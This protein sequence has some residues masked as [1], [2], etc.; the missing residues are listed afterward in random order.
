MFFASSLCGTVTI[1]EAV[2]VLAPLSLLT[3]FLSFCPWLYFHVVRKHLYSIS[4]FPKVFAHYKLNVAKAL[5][6]ISWLDELGTGL[7]AQAPSSPGCF[8]IPACS[9]YCRQVPLLSPLEP[10]S[11]FF[12]IKFFGVH[13]RSIF[14]FQVSNVPF[15][16]T[17]S[18]LKTQFAVMKPSFRFLTWEP[19][20]QGGWIFVT[21]Y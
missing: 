7:E 21:P 20:Q 12:N 11:F 1:Y 16:Y 2:S 9:C 5:P 15:H 17:H 6:I 19:S 10:K 3:L 18:R 14:F 4:L 13:S 8:S